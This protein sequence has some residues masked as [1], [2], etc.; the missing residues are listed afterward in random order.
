MVR[1]IIEP[2]EFLRY[3]GKGFLPDINYVDCVI[4]LFDGSHVRFIKSNF[5]T[6]K[7][8]GF[9]ND[10]LLVEENVAICSGFGI[11]CPAT[12]AAMEELIA[13]GAK[14]I[15]SFGTAG[16][17]S[18]GL[19]LGDVAVSV[20]S[21]SDEGTSGHYIS[22]LDYVYPHENLT[23]DLYQVLSKKFGNTYKVISWTTDAPFRETKEALT[24]YKSLGI[25]T[26]EME[27]SA[28]FTLGQYRNVEVASV[29]VIGDK[30]SE[31]G[32]S[33]GFLERIV[34]T[35]SKNALKHLIKYFLSFS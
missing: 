12:V 17:I 30:L 9:S 29:F 4:L 32:W 6:R 34:Q 10:C 20:K 14:R 21:K 18:P 1:A 7:L 2:L 3:L 8:T 15:I 28:I 11:G 33:P 27:S 26:I 31:D 13:A 19:K 16:S 23:L 24:K 22:S 35:R 25:N 5:R